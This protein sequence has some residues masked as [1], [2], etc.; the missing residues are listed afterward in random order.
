M[1]LTPALLLMLRHCRHCYRTMRDTRRC[2]IRRLCLRTFYEV[3]FTS[4]ADAR[5]YMLDAYRRY[6]AIRHAMIR[7]LRHIRQR[8]ITRLRYAA[9]LFCEMPRATFDFSPPLLRL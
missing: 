4:F 9:L 5:Y 2:L 6:A 8:V 7:Y 3:I 1:L